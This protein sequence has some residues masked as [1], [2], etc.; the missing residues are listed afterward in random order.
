MIKGSKLPPSALA[1]VARV[2]LLCL[3]GGALLFAA[4]P[5]FAKSKPAADQSEE[6]NPDPKSKT[7]KKSAKDQKDSKNPKDA[8]NQKDSKS[9]NGGVGKSE[10]IGTFVDWGAFATQGKDRTCY[11]MS[12]PK[13]RQPKTKLKD[14]TA[15]IFIS[16]RP[17]EGVKN[18]VAINLGYAAKENASASAEVGDQTFEL[19][20][21]GTNAWLKNQDEEDKFVKAAKTAKGAAK[22]T[23]KAASAKGTTTTD[24]YSLKGVSQALDRAVKECQ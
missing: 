4:A 8:K 9:Q 3:C 15:Y 17:G 16:M 5:A 20:T 6:K 2:S 19:I 18:E 13:D 21:K 7:D 10:Q 1:L 11:A 24:V 22:L 23:V 14:T 12:Q